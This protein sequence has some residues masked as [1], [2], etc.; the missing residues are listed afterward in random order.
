MQIV[1]ECGRI[2]C[3]E[4]VRS[5]VWRVRDFERTVTER[6]GPDLG[7]FCLSQAHWEGE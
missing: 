6:G 2:V 5:S 3:V 4:G 7:L 1:R